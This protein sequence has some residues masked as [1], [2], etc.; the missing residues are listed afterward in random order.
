VGFLLFVLQVAITI[1]LLLTVSMPWYIEDLAVRVG[2]YVLKIRG[3]NQ[4]SVE[5]AA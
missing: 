1:G 4:C 3:D 5:E 2:T